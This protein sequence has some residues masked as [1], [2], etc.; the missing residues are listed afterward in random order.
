M[1]GVLV[2]CSNISFAMNIIVKRALICNEKNF[3]IMVLYVFTSCLLIKIL[4]GSS[5]F[6]VFLNQIIFAADTL[7]DDFL[8]AE[9]S[10]LHSDINSSVSMPERAIGI[11]M[12]KNSKSSTGPDGKP[13]T[14]PSSG[15]SR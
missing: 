7:L 2:F 4:P 8:V 9:N 15:G 14:Q 6:T 3:I 1:E 12:S 5:G 11:P 10:P 13:E